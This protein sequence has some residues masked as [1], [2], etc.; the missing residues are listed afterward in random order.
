MN[1]DRAEWTGTA[2]AVVLLAALVRPT[3][4]AGIAVVMGGIALP[5]VWRIARRGR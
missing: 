4:I 2:A 3:D 1:F 5:H